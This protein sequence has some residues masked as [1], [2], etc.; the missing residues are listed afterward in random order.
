VALL[1]L[2]PTLS[3]LLGASD[4]DTGGVVRPLPVAAPTSGKLKAAPTG[5]SP[6]ACW[7]VMLR[8]S[9]TFLVARSRAREPKSG[10]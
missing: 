6:E 3:T 1:P 9:L 4:G 5:Y 8:N 10:T 7:V 2:L